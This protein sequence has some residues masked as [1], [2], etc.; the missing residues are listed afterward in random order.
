MTMVVV[1]VAAAAAAWT[2]ACEDWRNPF[3][4]LFCVSILAI[5]GCGASLRTIRSAGPLLVT[6]LS[7]AI[8][9]NS[10][11]AFVRPLPLRKKTLPCARPGR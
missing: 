1:V 9:A 5:L 11:D 8:P 4:M 6:V 10:F 3:W 7:H 2:S